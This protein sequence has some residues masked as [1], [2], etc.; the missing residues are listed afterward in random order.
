MAPVQMRRTTTAK[1]RKTNELSIYKRNSFAV[2]IVNKI[3]S[4]SIFRAVVR[5]QALKSRA[6]VRNSERMSRAGRA[7]LFVR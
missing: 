3:L 5:T 6:G 2:V 1:E 7:V 4:L